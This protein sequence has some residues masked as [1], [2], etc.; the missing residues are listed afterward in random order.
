MK[1]STD[2]ELYMTTLPT[3]RSSAS[4]CP[5]SKRVVSCRSCKKS[6]GRQR[7][8][9]E[10][11]AGMFAKEPPPDFDISCRCQPREL[12]E[13]VAEVGLIE[14]APANG[15]VAPVDRSGEIDREH[16]G[17]Q[18]VAAGQPL[19]RDADE[20]LEPL[21]QMSAADTG[22]HAQ[23]GD[24]HRPAGHRDHVARVADQP[25]AGGL[26]AP[27]HQLLFEQRQ[28]LVRSGRRGQPVPQ[29][30]NGRPAPNLLYR[31]RPVTQLGRGHRQKRRQ[32]P[33]L[34]VHADGPGLGWVAE[35]PRA[36]GHGDHA[37]VG[38][39]D[40]LDVGGAADAERCPEVDDEQRRRRRRQRQPGVRRRTLQVVEVVDQPVQ[41]RARGPWDRLPPPPHGRRPAPAR[42]VAVD[43]S[44]A[45]A[46]AARNGPVT[47]Q[48]VPPL[49]LSPMTPRSPA[50]SVSVPGVGPRCELKYR[51]VPSGEKTGPVTSL[52]S[53][54]V[55]ATRAKGTM[56]PSGVMRTISMLP[57]SSATKMSPD[58]AA[59]VMLS[60]PPRGSVEVPSHSCVY[61]WAAMSM[62]CTRLSPLLVK[63]IEP[64]WYQ[65]PSLPGNVVAA[66]TCSRQGV[67]AAD[68]S[69]TLTQVT[70]PAASTTAASSVPAESSGYASGVKRQS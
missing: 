5:K 25:E 1:P 37:A 69:D 66:D 4:G 45:A 34:E 11:V 33:G 65:T 9:V 22:C 57:P 24:R 56:S 51:R 43:G 54:P 29:L 28:H 16:G 18:A 8:A 58:A 50:M 59:T 55:S 52:P 39:L 31:H 3:G 38:V 6:I 21:C 49:R 47:S 15:E 42:V 63:T 46:A 70:A 14:V 53:W 36:G 35:L 7:P 61:R 60:T 26:T 17:G 68:G 30:S 44:P 40:R 13:L 67:V 20:L 27:S 23:V 41:W 19:R 2:T 62:A 64:S 10:R 32:P 12:P 48:V